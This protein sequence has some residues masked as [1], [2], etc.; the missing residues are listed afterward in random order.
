MYTGKNIII[1][2]V[3]VLVLIAVLG[4]AGLLYKQRPAS[5]ASSGYPAP[6]AAPVSPD[7]MLHM[8]SGQVQEVQPDRFTVSAV[9]P[10]KTTPVSVEVS[11]PGETAIKLYTQKAPAVLA[12]EMEEY[13]RAVAVSASTTA[14]VT[15]PVPFESSNATIADIKQGMSVSII[16]QDGTKQ[17]AKSV[18]AKSVTVYANAAAAFALPAAQPAPAAVP[19]PVP[20]AGPNQ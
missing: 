20:A 2:I 16:V 14:F 15:P 11:I 3:L 6:I 7:G 4:V 8:L 17:D 10:G 18:T 13:Q 5:Q 12:K 1:V 9:L 19:P